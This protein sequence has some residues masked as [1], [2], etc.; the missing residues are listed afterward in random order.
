MTIIGNK[1][2]ISSI[3][4]YINEILID[5]YK[6]IEPIHI[7]NIKEKEN[8]I[9]VLLRGNQIHFGVETYPNDQDKL[10]FIFYTIIK[11][12]YLQNA[13]KRT[14]TIIIINRLVYLF[15]INY[16]SI[17]NEMPEKKANIGVD[18]YSLAN[19]AIYVAESKSED[20]EIIM[21]ELI[22]FFKEIIDKIIYDAKQ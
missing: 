8:L 1:D 16:Y 9:D 6:D 2:E 18:F 3:I 14:A 19:K 21:K 4:D 13:N 5:V 22:Q 12:H 15:V 7:F 10:S 17:H 11:G 20:K